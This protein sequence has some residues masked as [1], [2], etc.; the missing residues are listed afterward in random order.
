VKRAIPTATPPQA[1]TQLTGSTPD[2]QEQI[3]L[4]AYEL[5]EQRENDSGHELDDWLQAEAEVM[6]QDGKTVAHRIGNRAVA[7]RKV[8]SE[9]PKAPHASS[10]PRQ[11]VTIFPGSW[12]RE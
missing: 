11:A 7:T 6:Q 5:Y 12:P 4:R 1:P 8:V 9:V 10:A 2:V 3:R